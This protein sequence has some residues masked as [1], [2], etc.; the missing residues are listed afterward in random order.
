MAGRS[1]SCSS[2]AAQRKVWRR[3][4]CHRLFDVCGALAASILCRDSCPWLANRRLVRHLFWARSTVNAGSSGSNHFRVHRFIGCQVAKEG[5]ISRPL[6]AGFT[7]HRLR[8]A[9]SRRHSRLREYRPAVDAFWIFLGW[10]DRNRL[11]H[12][13]NCNLLRCYG[14]PG[15]Q[16]PRV[17][18]VAV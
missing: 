14:C 13:G 3:G 17:D 7:S 4:I 18:V 9:P 5:S 2:T 15:R 6:D 1:G 8:R 11:L 12:G 16:A 10:A